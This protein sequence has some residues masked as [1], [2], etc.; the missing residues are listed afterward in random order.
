MLV[1]SSNKEYTVPPNWIG[2]LKRGFFVVKFQEIGSK[3]Y[4]IKAKSNRVVV[5]GLYIYNDEKFTNGESDYF[6]INDDLQGRAIFNKNGKRITDWFDDIYLVDKKEGPTYYQARRGKGWA[7]FL[8]NGKQ[9]SDWAEWFETSYGWFVG[10]SDFFVAS[11]KKGY[12]KAIFR[13]DGRMISDW[14]P[15]EKIYY[16]SLVDGKSDYFRVKEGSKQA[17]FDKNGSRITDWFSWIDLTGLVQGQSNYYIASKK[18]KVA[19]FHKDGY[20]VTEWFDYIYPYGLVEGKSDYYVVKD[21][22]KAYIGKLGSSK[23]LGPYQDLVFWDQAGI[24]SNPSITSITVHTLDDRKLD[25]SK[26]DVEK[27]FAEGDMDHGREK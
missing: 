8:I 6:V 24:I 17:I 22:Q 25:I 1:S 5:S 2:W 23:L 14:R 18:G 7:I 4:I 27:F 15:E 13:K 3:Y 10:K 12:E 21:R 16:K 20:Q 11:R 19:I 26:I 9:I